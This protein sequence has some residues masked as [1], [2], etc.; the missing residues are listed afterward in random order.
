MLDTLLINQLFDQ[1]LFFQTEMVAHRVLCVD[2]G[3]D[4]TIY[5]GKDAFQSTTSADSPL[6]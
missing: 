5:T 3:T 4:T 2:I 6:F 1:F